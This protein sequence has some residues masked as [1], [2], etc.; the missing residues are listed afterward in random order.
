MTD[1]KRKKC[2]KCGRTR[3][4]KFFGK[5]NSKVDGL[6][7]ACKDCKNK[8]YRENY[9]GEYRSKKHRKK[10]YGV[11]HEQYLQMIE[12]QKNSCAICGSKNPGRNMNNW[13]IDHCHETGKVRGLLCHNCNAGL[14]HF[15]DSIDNLKNAIKYLKKHNKEE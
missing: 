8:Y 1:I 12:S 11:D 4:V 5:C 13:N 3:L 15:K 6:Q 9:N 2:H 7:T 10:R 14:G